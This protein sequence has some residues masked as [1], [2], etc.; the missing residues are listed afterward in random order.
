MI[1]K[2]LQEIR[3]IIEEIYEAHGIYKDLESSP[4]DDGYH[5]YGFRA[6]LEALYNVL[7]DEE[8]ND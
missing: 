4:P 1:K 2:S 3:K 8:K 7:E 5:S 6:G